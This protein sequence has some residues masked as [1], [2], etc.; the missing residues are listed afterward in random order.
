LRKWDRWKL[1]ILPSLFPF[2][3]TGAITA[4]GGAWNASIVAEYVEFQGKA[5]YTVGVGATIAEATKN[6][7]FPLLL[8]STLCM[9]LAVVTINRFVW[10]RLYKLAE[11]RFHMD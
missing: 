8:A 1:F 3:V 9:V 7:D 6:G 11:D 10:R 2:I 5:H 4:S